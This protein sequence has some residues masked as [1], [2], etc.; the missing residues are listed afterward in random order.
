MLK[1]TDYFIQ[2]Y[3]A[4]HDTHVISIDTDVLQLF[5]TYDWPGNVRELE[6]IVERLCTINNNRTITM[7]AV[8][9]AGAG[10]AVCSCKSGWFRFCF[11]P[12]RFTDTIVD[13]TEYF[14][15]TVQSTDQHFLS[16]Q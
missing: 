16:D 15:R 7:K 10:S 2:K 13:S 1:L 6:H 8:V 4:E 11:D 12:I 5:Q 9:P 3:N 14:C